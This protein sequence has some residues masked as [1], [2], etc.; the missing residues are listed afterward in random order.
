MVLIFSSPWRLVSWSKAENSSSRTCTTSWGL[1]CWLRR[2]KST[3]SANS[4]VTSGKPSAI[5][6]SC[7]LSRVAIGAGNTFSSSRSDC[8]SSRS[9][10]RRVRTA[11]PSSSTAA[12]ST[13]SRMTSPSTWSAGWCGAK[14]W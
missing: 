11:S 4:T 10:A 3:R 1:L 2:V 7:C 13:M 14:V 5:T 9:R 6:S 8:S 12:N